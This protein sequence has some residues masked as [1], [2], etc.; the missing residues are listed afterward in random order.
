MIKI[1]VPYG[2]TMQKAEIPDS[3]PVQIIDPECPPVEKNIE[4][5]IEAALDT[6]IG[7]P[8]LED[9]VTE[10]DHVLIV[11]NDHT[12]PG[13]NKELAEGVAGRLKKAG[14]PDDHITFIIA[15]GSHRGSTDQEIDV[16][17]GRDLHS[18]MKV[19]NHDCKKNNVYMGQLDN[20]LPLYIDRLAVDA[21][22]IVTTGLVAP[23]KA[24]GFSGGRKSIVPG[25]TGLETLK[26]HHSLPIRPFEPALGWMEENPFHQAAVEAAKKVKV[27]FILNA[28][29][30]THKQN[31][32]VVAGDLERAHEEGVR[33]CREHN[34]VECDKRGD[35]I[36]AS[37]GGA[38]RDC[39]LY[40]AQ[41]ALATEEVFAAAS[42]NTTLVLVARAEDGIGPQLFQ[43]WLIEADTPDQ[44]IERFRT[45]GFD[46]GTNKAFEYARAMKK[47]KVVIVSE[48]VDSEQLKKM[49]ID[50]APDLQT[51]VDAALK[52]FTPQ[53]VIVL[54]KAV[55][56][57]P[58]FKN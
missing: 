25:V 35:L 42:K 46:V 11:V 7:T 12:R 6:P 4:E 18:R 56:I 57:I 1:E 52:R 9:M 26:I 55:S 15:T 20:G 24:A 51:A 27:R 53:Q 48:N 39:N 58:H 45:E 36:I 30:D 28:V 37:P 41:K 44:V 14:V 50:W 31:V 34:T 29:Q 8:R 3:I 38:P 47:G 23:H 32:A 54:P 40:Q 2:D 17:I 10:K 22:F 49:K 33:I 13:P 21:D 5:L 43:D 16:L 19:V